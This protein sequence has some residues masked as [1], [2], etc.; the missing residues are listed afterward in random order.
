[1]ATEDRTCVGWG[2][3]EGKCREPAGT[4]WTPHWCPRCDEA[5]RA[6]LTR[7]LQELTGQAPAEAD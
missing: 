3:L 5:R 4:P 1:M 7:R 2:E 6:H